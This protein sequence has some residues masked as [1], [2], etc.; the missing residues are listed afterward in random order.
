[1]SLL[2]GGSALV[3]GEA[4]TGMMVLMEELVRR[5][6]DAGPPLS[7]VVMMPPGAAWGRHAGAAFTYAQ[8]LAE[9]GF[10]EGTKGGVQTVFLRGP[11]A[12]G[13]AESLPGPEPA[14]AIIHPSLAQAQAQTWPP[15]EPAGSTSR[16]LESS[17]VED[18]HR[19]LAAGARQALARLAGDPDTRPSRGEPAQARHILPTAKDAQ[20]TARSPPEQQRRPLD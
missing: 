6:A 20:G 14:D 18:G 5:L 17:A 3:V 2:A 13:P 16:A 9:D 4:R 8:A 19:T 1:V 12:A 10:S 15:V 7:L 11:E